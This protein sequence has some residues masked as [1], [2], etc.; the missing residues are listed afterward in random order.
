M[1]NGSDKTALAKILRLS[2]NAPDLNIRTI[3][4]SDLKS[5]EDV[6][7]EI[8]YVAKNQS[9]RNS[10][11]SENA[12]CAIFDVSQQR[13]LLVAFTNWSS[14]NCE[15]NWHTERLVDE[16]LQATNNRA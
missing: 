6:M 2:E 5:M 3:T 11:N 14:E 12:N 10:A 15:E 13:E 9:E 1:D 16:Y 8:Y 7:A 4:E